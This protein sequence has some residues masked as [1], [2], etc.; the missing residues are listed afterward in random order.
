MSLLLSQQRFDL[1]RPKDLFLEMKN[2]STYKTDALTSKMWILPD[3]KVVSLGEWHYRWVMAN[4]ARLAKYGLDVT[5]LPD[6]ETAVRVASIKAGLFRVNYEH[7]NGSITIEGLKNKKNRL[8]KDAI[9]VIVMENL[10]AIDRVKITLFDDHAKKVIQSDEVAIFS[11]HT[12]EEKLSA[13]DD[14]LR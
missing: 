7:G 4:K 13:L 5:K 3:G 6:D 1:L 9:F 2:V 12:D 8:V 10:N 14:I 11:Y